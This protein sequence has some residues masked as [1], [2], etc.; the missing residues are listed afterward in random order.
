[1]RIS[2][3]RW[4][5]VVALVGC[6][7][8]PKETPAERKHDAKAAVAPPVVADAAAIAAAAVDAGSGGNAMSNDDKILEEHFTA[9]GWGKP[10]SVVPN[11]HVPGLYRAEFSTG[12]GTAHVVV[13]DG[14][15]LTE[16]GVPALGKYLQAIKALEQPKLDVDDMLVL[17]QVFAAYP[18][19][20][21]MGPDEFYP[22]PDHKALMPR[23]EHTRSKGQLVLHY[24]QPNRGGA[25]PNANL[26]NAFR[27]IL[28][29]PSD[30]ALEWTDDEVEVDISK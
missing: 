6:T 2:V 29:V 24:L 28:A 30:Y 8:S 27:F 16:Q 11:D 15:V 9:L 14:K 1:M 10:N 20:G 3:A 12:S 17:L 13:H 21:V 23:F 4:I 25:R 7:K 5:V 18:E 26:R 22:G 19:I